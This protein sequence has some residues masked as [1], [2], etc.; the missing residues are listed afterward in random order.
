M[1][2]WSNRKIGFWGPISQKADLREIRVCHWMGPKLEFSTF[3]WY[4]CSATFLRS[5]RPSNV[6]WQVWG[7]FR[8]FGWRL[9]ELENF[10]PEPKSC[11]ET[12]KSGKKS[13]L[14]IARKTHQ[15][16]PKSVP[17]KFLTVLVITRWS[18][19]ISATHMVLAR[20]P[21]FGPFLTHTCLEARKSHFWGVSP[22][23]MQLRL[24]A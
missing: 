12:F 8:H 4:W 5:I 23:G 18:E 22:M 1:F 7:S 11:T 17:Y 9:V 21:V 15:N 20:Y 19:S 10:D 24:Y 14:F 13:K 6:F 3:L 16:M 2:L